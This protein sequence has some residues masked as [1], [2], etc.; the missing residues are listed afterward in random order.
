VT[1]A[2]VTL[3]DDPARAAAMGEKG[4]ARGASMFGLPAMADAI[5]SV[6]RRVTDLRPGTAPRQ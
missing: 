1:A 2:I 6:Y 5:A 3:L 4:R